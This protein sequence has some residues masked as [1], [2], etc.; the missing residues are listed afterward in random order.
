MRIYKLDPGT[1]YKRLAVRNADGM[2]ALGDS[3][4]GK[5]R[6]TQDNQVYVKSEDEA[7]RLVL[8]GHYI[9]VESE[10]SPSLVRK[11][12]YVDGTKVS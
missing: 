6:H 5:K 2:F 11:N 9:R 7:V 10:T 12:L 3:A 4:L 1:T 8:S